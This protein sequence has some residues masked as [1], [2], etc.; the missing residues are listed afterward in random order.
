MNQV[1]KT[2]FISVISTNLVNYGYEKIN[3]WEPV[4]K[5]K[6]AQK[7]RNNN[8]ELVDYKRDKKFHYVQ[9]CKAVGEIKNTLRK[10]LQCGGLY[11]LASPPGCGKSAH[12]QDI[13]SDFIK[14]SNDHHVIVVKFDASEILSESNLRK[15]LGVPAY[16]DLKDVLP[17]GSWIIIDQLDRNEVGDMGGF[18]TALAT[19]S[20][21]SC[22][23]FS[24][25]VCVSK[26]RMF[27]D[28]LECNGGQKILPVCNPLD[29]QVNESYIKEYIKA[30]RPTADVDTLL[31]ACKDSRSIGVARNLVLHGKV[32][33]VKTD[34][35]S[36]SVVY[37]SFYTGGFWYRIRCSFV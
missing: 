24:V 26:A 8:I 5:F 14:Q 31:V 20:N 22:G 7:M 34:W 25:M 27:K 19:S 11:V 37:N 10:G 9:G 21:N 2:A 13:L 3:A 6:M 1:A 12:L 15:K 18:F 33:K 29:F 23:N 30:V 16:C 32:A 36:F 4:V 35:D 28:I 17:T